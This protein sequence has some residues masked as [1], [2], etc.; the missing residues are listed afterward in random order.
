MYSPF[1][2]AEPSIIGEI[3]SFEIDSDPEGE[4]VAGISQTARGLAAG[5]GKVGI[6]PPTIP[7]AVWMMEIAGENL[8]DED[9]TTVCNLCHQRARTPF[10]FCKYCGA[11][12]SLHHG[13]C[14]PFRYALRI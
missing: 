5:N 13:K 14:C 2:D 9:I 12:P 10:D 3:D 6:V 8:D 7:V 4:A 1:D 11:T